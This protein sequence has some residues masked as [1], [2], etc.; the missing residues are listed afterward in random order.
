MSQ[1]LKVS[2]RFCFFGLV[3]FY[4]TTGEGASWLSCGGED[5]NQFYAYVNLINYLLYAFTAM[6]N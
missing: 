4:L 5:H 6:N 1:L 2:I 3:L